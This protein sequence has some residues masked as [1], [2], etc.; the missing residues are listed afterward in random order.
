[1]SEL[2]SYFSYSYIQ[3]ALICGLVVSLAASL[4]GVSLVLKRFSMIGDGLSHVGFGVTSLAAVLNI[5]NSIMFS[6]PIVIVAALFLLRLNEK[7]K[8]KGD[9]AIALVATSALAFGYIIS[10]A[11]G[12][13]SNVD[14]CTFL[15]GNLFTINPS[16]VLPSI[17]LSVVVIMVFL[18]LYNKLFLVTFD[19]S[20]ASASGVRAGFYNV[21]IAT[22][23]SI[24][25]VVGMKIMGT[26]LI[27]ALI[28]F[29]SLTSMRVCKSFKS[30]VIVA[31]IISVVSCVVG[32]VLGV[33]FELP[34]GSIIV[35]VNLFAFILFCLIDYV[36]RNRRKESKQ[37]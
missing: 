4:L 29:P 13:T 18:L 31:G 6:I 35:I 14:V 2:L 37:T 24:T 16:E 17:I 23:T 12:R 30:V 3:Y 32:V 1:M 27:S 34:G 8:L 26:L 7:G 33:M 10:S 20:F 25:I 36:K 21:L 9:A 11:S 19:E 28:V 22:L 15:F 5:T